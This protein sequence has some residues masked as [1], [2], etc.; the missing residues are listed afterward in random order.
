MYLGLAD[1]LLSFLYN[2]VETQDKNAIDKAMGDLKITCE[3]KLQSLRCLANLKAKD[4]KTY[5]LYLEP[6]I[7]RPFNF[8]SNADSDLDVLNLLA[9]AFGRKVQ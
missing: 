1:E 3:G 4:L 8:T 6:I 7:F 5:L 9:Q 2:G